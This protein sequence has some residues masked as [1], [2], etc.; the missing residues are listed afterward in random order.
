[1]REWVKAKL[2]ASGEGDG[3]SDDEAIRKGQ[4]DGEGKF[5]K[6]GGVNNC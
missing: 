3:V 1:M 6:I 5:V 2:R 4:G